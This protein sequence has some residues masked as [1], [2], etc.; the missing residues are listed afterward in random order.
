LRVDTLQPLGSLLL[1][2]PDGV[3]LA[4]KSSQGD[5]HVTN[6]T[7]VVDVSAAKGDVQIMVPAYAQASIGEGNLSATMGSTNWPGTLHFTLGHGDAEV[8]VNENTAFHVRL[9]T[10]NGMLFTDFDLRGT[11]HGHSET[12][13]GMINGGGPRSIDIETRAGA[14]RL[15]KLHPQ[16]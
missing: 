12:I 16:A 13:D 5:V 1:R 6:I 7:G 9:H 14:I 3:A 4:I 2:V 11:S 15:L 10:D 8:W